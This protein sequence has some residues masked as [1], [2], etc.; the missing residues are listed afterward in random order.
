MKIKLSRF[1]S[2]PTEFL[3]QPV[4]DKLDAQCV[5]LTDGSGYG[6]CYGPWINNKEWDGS[7]VICLEDNR[8]AYLYPLKFKLLGYSI[9][10]VL[11]NVEQKKEKKGKVVGN[12]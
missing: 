12:G 3:M 7:Y 5:E 10:D 2:G 4:T 1:R 6:A 11:R 8:V 9:G